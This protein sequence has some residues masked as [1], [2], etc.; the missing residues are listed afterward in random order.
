[1]RLRK[2]FTLVFTVFINVLLICIS[3][4]DIGAQEKDWFPLVIDMAVGK[5]PVYLRNRF[6]TH[7]PWAYVSA[8]SM[9]RNL[10]S[11]WVWDQ[12][13]Y[14]TNQFGH[15][16]QGAL[17]FSAAR[18]NGFSFYEALP[19]AIIGSW[20]WEIFPETNKPS[21]N[22]MIATPLGGAALGEMMHRLFLETSNPVLA[23]LISPLDSFNGFLTG[24][25]PRR[26]WTQLRSLTYYLGAYYTSARGPTGTTMAHRDYH[27]GNDFGGMELAINLVYGDPFT[28]Q[29]A[30][31]YDQF[32]LYTSVAGFSDYWIDFRFVSDGYLYSFNPINEDAQKLSTGVS[33]Q[34][35]VFGAQAVEYSQQGLDWTVKYRRNLNTGVCLELRTHLG[36]T[37]FGAGNLYHW[38]APQNGAPGR[39]EFE[40]SYGTGANAKF[41]FSLVNERGG[42]FNVRALFYYLY[43]ISRDTPWSEGQ[44]FYYYI[45]NDYLFPLSDN[46]ALG[47]GDSF[48]SEIGWYPRSQKERVVKYANTVRIYLNYK[49]T[50]G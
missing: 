33:F 46:L 14:M 18:A 7:D 2:R 43:I 22:D 38:E 37:M 44:N 28:A 17:D 26:G 29:S 39:F 12:D 5:L 27:K 32:E 40:R 42:S 41:F 31:P 50:A 11:A 20:I 30:T 45:D 15:P 4:R 24:R 25:K 23:T 6:I 21:I 8:E 1:V 3:Y 49:I 19:V 13:E 16:Y 48:S 35:D 34:F 9:W 47:L 36:W 10:H